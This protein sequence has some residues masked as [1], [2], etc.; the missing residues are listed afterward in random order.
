[1]GFD[2]HHRFDDKYLCAYETR[3]SNRRDVLCDLRV[4]YPWVWALYTSHNALLDF[5]EHV[6]M[7]QA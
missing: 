2:A 1:M 7:V 3:E 5:G 6:R 4:L